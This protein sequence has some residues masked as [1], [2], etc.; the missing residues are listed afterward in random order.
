MARKKLALIWYK[1]IITVALCIV[2]MGTAREDTKIRCL[3]NT[4]ESN[5]VIQH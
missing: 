1:E 4:L 5:D 3:G 2:V